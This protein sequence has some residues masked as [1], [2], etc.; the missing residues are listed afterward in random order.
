MINKDFETGT[1]EVE[2]EEIKVIS[3]SKTPP[4]EI[5][6]EGKEVN[7]ELRMKYRYLDLRRKRML[8]NLENRFKIIKNA[9]DYL[10]EKGFLEIETPIISKSTPEGARDYL[11]PAR[12]SPGN[13]YALPQSPQ[14]YKQLL[15]VAGIEK[16]FQ[17]ARCFRDEDYRGD[18][19]T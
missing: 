5:N 9:R 6:D 3:K 4:F 18:R 2:A 1:V 14:Q 16:Y 12:I 10:T 13:F 15:M 8:G 11:V 7:E 19:Q 17:V